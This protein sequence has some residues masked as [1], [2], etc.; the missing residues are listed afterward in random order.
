MNPPLPKSERARFVRH[1]FLGDQ[2]NLKKLAKITN[3]LDNL[4]ANMVNFAN[5]RIFRPCFPPKSAKKRRSITHSNWPFVFSKV[6]KKSNQNRSPYFSRKT[7]ET[8]I[9]VK[10]LTG[11]EAVFFSWQLL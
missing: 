1:C 3:L 10:Y 8:Y 5:C 6:L 9:F 2:K 4:Y 11:K 7:K